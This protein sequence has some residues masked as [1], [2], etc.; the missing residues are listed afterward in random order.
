MNTDPRL[1]LVCYDVADDKRRTKVYKTL[2][3]FGDHLQY[4]VFR[5]A[6][7]PMQLGRLR[8]ELE[9]VIAPA[10]DQVLMVLLGHAE[11]RKSWR[12]ITIGRAVEAPSR[13]ARII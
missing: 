12:T 3:G 7:S 10:E 11:S 6:L 8:T 13:K 4:S 5:C 9:A 1:W 2:R